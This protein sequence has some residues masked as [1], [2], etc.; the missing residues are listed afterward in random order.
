MVKVPK[1]AAHTYLLG[2][3][4]IEDSH[5]GVTG[6]IELKSKG[7]CSPLYFNFPRH[8]HS[9]GRPGHNPIVPMRK[10]PLPRQCNPQYLP[11]Y[12][13]QCS[14]HLCHQPPHILPH[15]DESLAGRIETDV[16]LDEDRSVLDRDSV[17]NSRLA[18]IKVK[19]RVPLR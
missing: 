16:S 12:P 13:S 6:H 11:N 14:I 8:L 15:F 5:K 7:Q 4:P 1:A 2:R 9:C 17:V 10:V 19:E 18:E 3:Q